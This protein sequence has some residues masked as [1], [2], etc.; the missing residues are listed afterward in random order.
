[1]AC[2]KI[3]VNSL[4]T[5]KTIVELKGNGLKTAWL[6][7]LPKNDSLAALETAYHHL[8]EMQSAMSLSD[9]LL[10]HD[11]CR[12]PLTELTQRYTYPQK[13]AYEYE[14]R[15]WQVVHDYLNVKVDCYITV[16]SQPLDNV[17]YKLVER[18][19]LQG[20][21][22]AAILAKWHYLRYQALPKGLWLKIHQLYQF[23]EKA[24]LASGGLS[25]MSRSLHNGR[26]LQA[27]MLDLLNH[28]N[29]LKSEIEMVNG[30]LAGWSL[31]LV[32]DD[33]YN[34][35]QHLFFVDFREDRGARRIRSFEPVHGCRYWNTDAVVALIDEMRQHLENGVEP[36]QFGKDLHISAALRLTDH[37]MSAWSRIGYRRQRRSEDRAGVIKSALAEHGISSV[38]QHVKNLAYGITAIVP[39]PGEIQQNQ[40]EHWR[41]KNESQYG[42]GAEVNTDSNRWLQ[43]GILIALDYALNPDMTVIGVVRSIQQQSLQGR[44]VGIEVLSHTPSYVRLQRL[45][46]NSGTVMKGVET[47]SALYLSRDE[48]RGLPATIIMA[49]LDFVQ[50]SIYELSTYELSHL[51]RLGLVIEQ[52]DDWIRVAAILGE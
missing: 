3:M 23:S 4:N 17:S 5:G 40:D 38:C 48:R 37:L 13:L 15:L 43:P 30:W 14:A 21:D 47:L 10:V 31:E 35:K 46:D 32:L 42:I 50:D 41:I 6:K 26:Y 12:P 24:I 1:M 51:V 7:N 34:E 9:L 28:S 36:A 27:L 52:Q 33:S 19:L 20:L 39:M 16:N 18:C 45:V 22:S 25:Q 8:A 2:Q 49:V 11:A 44:Y 29:L